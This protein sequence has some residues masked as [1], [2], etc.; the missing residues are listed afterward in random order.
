MRV[1]QLD[2]GNA[3]PSRPSASTQAQ[4]SSQ[5][6]L[7]AMSLVNKNNCAIYPDMGTEVEVHNLLIIDQNTFEGMFTNC[8]MLPIFD[9][10]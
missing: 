4:S 2:G 3:C 10:R 8:A 9:N 7:S 1:D 6:T 5:S